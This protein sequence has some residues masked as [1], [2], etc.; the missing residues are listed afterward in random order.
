MLIVF[1]SYFTEDILN[2]YAAFIAE[3]INAVL[4]AIYSPS[5]LQPHQKLCESVVW[6]ATTG[7]AS[8][9]AGKQFNHLYQETFGKAPSFSQ[10]S[11][12]F[13]QVNILANVWRKSACPR[14]FSQVNQGIRTLVNHDINGAYFFGNEHQIGL[15]YPDSTDD[16]SISQPH[17]IYQIQ[18]GRNTVIAPSLFAE[19]RFELPKW[20][21][22]R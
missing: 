11:P 4:Y 16:L 12:A 1:A 22:L 13:D 18:Q 15:T 8:T 9:Y 2:F 20:F 7:L 17:L 5:T 3:P 14:H 19:S 10:A 21:D 6:A